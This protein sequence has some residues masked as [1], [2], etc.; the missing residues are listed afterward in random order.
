MTLEALANIGEFVSSLAVLVSLIYLAIQIKRSTETAR[1]S[2]YQAIVSDFGAANQVLAS[3]PE[4]S[5]IY[6]EALENYET[7]EPNDKARISQMF[8]MTFR[9]FENMFYQNR[10]GYLDEEVWRGWARLMVTYF[11]RPGF[12][13]WWQLRREV[14]S[15]PFVQFLESEDAAAVVP[16]Y[17][18]VTHQKGS[19]RPGTGGPAGA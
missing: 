17:H 5:W 7:L 10:K 3:S 8:Y 16:S 9:Y 13:A 15:E 14:F 6:M 4:L 1:T 2:T 19:P 12:Q 11:R 18:D